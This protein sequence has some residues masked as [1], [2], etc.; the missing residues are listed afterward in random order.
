MLNLIEFELNLASIFFILKSLLKLILPIE[1]IINSSI[2]K[3]S[4]LS[5]LN[6]SEKSNLSDLKIILNW[7]FESVRFKNKLFLL[8]FLKLPI[9]I[10]TS[11]LELKFV[12]LISTGFNSDIFSLLNLSLLLLISTISNFEKK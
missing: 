11:G 7:L 9:E 5:S 6:T 8:S 4:N 2:S 10:E 1:E 3:L 12:I